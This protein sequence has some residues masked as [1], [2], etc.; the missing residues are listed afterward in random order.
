GR[1]HRRDRAEF[2]SDDLPARGLRRGVERD[3]IA[4]ST[5]R[6]A[7][8]S[9]LPLPLWGGQGSKIFGYI[10]R[11]IVAELRDHRFHLTGRIAPRTGPE[12]GK[13]AQHV[14]RLQTCQ[15]GSRRREAD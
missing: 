6:G 13:L 5:P 2:A 11:V 14:I 9:L 15:I 8:P 4:F 12:G 1:R 3:K 7:T 10:H